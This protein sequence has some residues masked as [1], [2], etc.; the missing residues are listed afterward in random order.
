MVALVDTMINVKIRAN[1]SSNGG[2]GRRWKKNL[3]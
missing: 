3:F 2:H 1:G